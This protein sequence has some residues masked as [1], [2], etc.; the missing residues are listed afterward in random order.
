MVKLACAQ[1][2]NQLDK[3]DNTKLEAI[4]YACENL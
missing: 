3:L 4:K 1:A 2:N